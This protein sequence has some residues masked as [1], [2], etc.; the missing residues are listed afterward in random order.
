MGRKITSIITA[1]LRFGPTVEFT[2]QELEVARTFAEVRHSGD[3]NRI[4]N[5]RITAAYFFVNVVSVNSV[6]GVCMHNPGL[7]LSFAGV[8]HPSRPATTR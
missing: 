5:T 6:L 4:A 7:A 3:N 2:Q 1:Q 8:L